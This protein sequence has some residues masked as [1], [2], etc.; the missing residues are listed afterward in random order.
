MLKVYIYVS[1]SGV[2]SHKT[3]YKGICYY[4]ALRRFFSWETLER[5]F[6][7]VQKV[8]KDE[9]FFM[10]FNNSSSNNFFFIFKT[11]IGFKI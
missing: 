5:N 3:H 10:I 11:Y 1:I 4:R 2:T 6:L 7:D 8:E 9:S